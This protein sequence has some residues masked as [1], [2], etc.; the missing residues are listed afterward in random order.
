APRGHHAP[1]PPLSSVRCLHNWLWSSHVG[2]CMA[3][4]E[5]VYPPKEHM[6]LLAQPWICDT[7][8]QP[9]QALMGVVLGGER[10][11]KRTFCFADWEHYVS[12][13]FHLPKIYSAHDGT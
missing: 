5:M 7:C 12:Q 3:I 6:E 9:V 4:T 13:V 11:Q 2:A 1:S 10:S 8:G